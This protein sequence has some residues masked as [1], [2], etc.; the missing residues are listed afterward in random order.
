MTDELGRV[1]V[2]LDGDPEVKAV[3]LTGA[4]DK[5]SVGG[6]FRAMRDGAWASPFDSDSFGKV[7]KKIE[8]LLSLRVPVIAAVNGDV[9]GGAATWVLLC[10]MV[11]MAESARI[12]DP[13]VRS[14]AVA[15]DGGSIIWP[16][17]C[18]PLRAKQYL[19]TG[20][21][22]VAREAERIGLATKVVTD[23]TAYAEAVKQARRFVDE[24]A[25]LAVRWTKYSINKLIRQQMLSALDVSLALELITF[26][27]EDRK[28]AIA[29]FLEKR[30]PT[31]KGR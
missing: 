21:L 22:M 26:M 20:D 25:P 27:S 13:H 12:G 2:E 19:M 7:P 23:G 14:G 30:R 17:I 10:D 18:G 3:I 29:S 16:L 24:R 15:G 5:F 11:I 9:V 28:E 1:W 4:G 6:D 8:A 31:F